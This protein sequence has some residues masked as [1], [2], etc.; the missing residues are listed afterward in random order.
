[1]ALKLQA[2]EI[3]P[4]D[5]NPSE[6]AE[7]INCPKSSTYNFFDGVNGIHEDKNRKNVIDIQKIEANFV[8][9]YFVLM[10]ERTA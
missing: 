8:A 1:M 4:K 5:I 10:F 3:Y 7:N 2:Y 6:A 9:F